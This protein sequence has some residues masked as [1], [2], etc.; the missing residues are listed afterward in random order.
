MSD[1]SLLT[2]PCEVPVKIVGRNDAEFRDVA[3]GIVSK[4]YSYLRL[5]DVGEQTS[6]NGAYVSL[7]FVVD[8][9]S[10]GEID[11]LYRELTSTE[12]I[13]MVF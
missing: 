11:A 8:A 6:R 2:F 12:K 4:H 13:I 10:R 7:T 1:D 9:Q 5:S 3:Q